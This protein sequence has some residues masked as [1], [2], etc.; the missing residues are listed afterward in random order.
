MLSQEFINEVKE[1]NDITDVIGGYV[2]LKR[3][4]RNSKGL[5]PFH[6]EKTPS[7]TVYTDTASFYCFGCQTGGD[8]IGFIRKIEN[9]DYVEAVKFLANRAGIAVPEEGKNDGLSHMRMRIREQNREAG[10]F[11]Y[12]SLYSPAGKNALE[13][14][15]S[16]G[17]TDD[18][19]RRFGL[20]WSPDGWD[21]LVRHLG[22]LGYKR[23]EILAADLGYTSRK[24]GIIDRF[25]NRVMFPIIDLQGNVVAFGGRKFTDDVSGGKYVNTS[26][27]LIYRKTNNLFAMNMAKN[28]KSR[29]LILCEGYMDVIALHQAGFSNAVAALGTAVTPQQ[30]RIIHKYADRVILSQDGDE[31]GQK[32]IARSIPIMKDEGL[33]V[34]VLEITGAKDPDEFIKKYGPE[35]FKML[36]DGCSN[37]IEYSIMRIGSKYDVSTDDGRLHYLREV[38]EYLG[39]L[40][41][42]EREVYAARIADKLRVEKNAVLSQAEASARRRKKSEMEK[43]F[44]EMAKTTA[45][46]G[47]KINPERSVKLRAS[48]AEYALLAILFNHQD[49]IPKAAQELPPSDF[50]T[51]F[52]KRIYSAF[53]ELN[54]SG[55][56]VSVS[57]LSQQFSDEETSEIVK[58]INSE[59]SVGTN[60]YDNFIEIIRKEHFTPDPREAAKLSSEELLAQMY[61]MKKEKK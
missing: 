59:K 8:V 19:I 53:I 27:T 46:I 47:N 39:G 33:D 29:E 54:Q 48:N 7:F 30:A 17:L 56:E 3:S 13:Y 28:S 40:G 43:D 11:F 14:F 49:M 26:D 45:G 35:R 4:G 2:N 15:R 18:T 22:E 58:I 1:R 41:N 51:D 21:M 12:R 52:G 23:D 50:V 9:L 61:R 60:D 32:S 5:C 20:G 55:Q 25:R 34:R 38:C 10:R 31:A 6:S 44:R 37:D 36:L 16:R 24:G 42:L 57:L